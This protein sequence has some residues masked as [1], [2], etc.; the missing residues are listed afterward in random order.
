MKKWQ[1]WCEVKEL[2]TPHFQKLWTLQKRDD[3]ELQADFGCKRGAEMAVR[4]MVTAEERR[5]QISM[6]EMP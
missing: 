3:G 2:S 6:A 5:R 4:E 1:T